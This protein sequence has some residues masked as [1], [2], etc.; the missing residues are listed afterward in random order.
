VRLSWICE[1]PEDGKL[2]SQWDD[3]VLESE[4]PEVFLTWEWAAAVARAYKSS[5]QPWIGAAY[6]GEE[7]VGIAALA[8]T[9]PT[10]AAFLAGSTAD[11][12]DFI[13]R[14]EK[15]RE[16]VTLTLSSLK[17]DGI[18]TILLPNLPAD[19]ATVA[20]LRGNRIFRSF[21][22]LGYV[23][24]Q[25]RLGSEE[26][27]RSLS[28]Q[29]LKKS[30]FRRAMQ[31]LERIGS[32]AL[33]HESGE[34]LRGGLLDAFVLAHVA[35]FLATRR[36]GNLV[37]KDRRQFL[38]ELARLLT[39]RGWF[40]L[41]TLSVGDREVGF[42]YGFRYKGNWSWYQPAIVNEFADSS[43]G[44]CLLT[45]I[46]E[47]ACKDPQAQL[48]DLGLG[49]ESYK[50]RFANAQRTT[51][52]VTLSSGA[53]DHWRARGRYCA[54]TAIKSRPKVELLVR[55]A[56][57][58]MAS[59]RRRV[60]KNALISMLA[61][62]GKHL[63]RFPACR[64]EVWLYQWRKG[65]TD[66][67]TGSRLLPLSWETL[68]AAAMKHSEHGDSL[69]YLLRAAERL[70]EQRHRGYALPGEDG[71]AEHFAWVA[72]YEGFAISQL[73]DVLRAPSPES[74]IIFDCGTPCEVQG[75]GRFG[76][77]IEQLAARLS[78]EGKDVWIFSTADTASRAAIENAGFRMQCSLVKRR[79]LFWSR[80]SQESRVTPERKQAEALSKESVR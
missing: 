79:V 25:V 22:R 46:V 53:F 43:P 49:T 24:A 54:A 45:K 67:E 41:M 71:I 72:P 51:L 17:Q 40:D 50:E 61:S 28:K 2:R 74:V 7:L 55:Q 65:P 13:S 69:E 62:A 23:C 47:D 80:T 33:R 29:M 59:T 42:N 16:F 10:G 44:F 27:R 11:Y 60:T 52:H 21:L 38:S 64:D 15:R 20:A 26:E 30:M 58:G 32:V 12:C 35:R 48:V 9:S 18:R 5:L 4:H 34:G 19:S 78:A 6:E 57:R 37:T 70:R 14:P 3:L 31:S 8:K 73:G 39:E 63:R 56:Q 75:Q 1:L 68:A 66:A 76:V 36:L 77:T